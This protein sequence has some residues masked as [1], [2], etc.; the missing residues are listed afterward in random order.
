ML[1]LHAVRQKQMQHERRYVP[2]G[3][4]PGNFS[5]GIDHRGQVPGWGHGHPPCPRGSTRFLEHLR[6][7]DLALQL[8]SAA[9]HQRPNPHPMRSVPPNRVVPL[10]FL[11]APPVS[12]R[13]PKTSLKYPSFNTSAFHSNFSREN[14]FSLIL[15]FSNIMWPGPIFCNCF[16]R[17]PTIIGT[18][19]A[20][21]FHHIKY[22]RNDTDNYR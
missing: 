15:H 17:L 13:K 10:V 21:L 9:V 22:L 2:V 1:D 20:Q 5:S 12:P 6:V 14:L 4:N 8:R 16:I 18:I 19:V 3:P 11:C 7:V